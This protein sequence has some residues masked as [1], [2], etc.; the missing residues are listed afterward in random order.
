MIERITSFWTE[1][2]DSIS[3]FIDIFEI[4][5]FLVNI[6]VFSLI[7]RF[8]KNFWYKKIELSCG[9]FQVKRKYYDVQ[10]ITNL[11]SLHFYDG[12]IVPPEVRKEILEKTSPKIKDKKT[13]SITL[14]KTLWT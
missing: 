4:L 1:N 6:A 12:G 13:A 10:N 5:D 11:V 2:S 8:W 14:K 7:L 3:L 9:S